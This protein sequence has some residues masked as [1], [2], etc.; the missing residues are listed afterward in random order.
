MADGSYFFS[1][2]I[3]ASW[4]MIGQCDLD[5]KCKTNRNQNTSQTKIQSTA[6][7]FYN[8]MHNM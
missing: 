3:K 8:F 7:R 2:N 1:G 5:N 4:Y 6:Y